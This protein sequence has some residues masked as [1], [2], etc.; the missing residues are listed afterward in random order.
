MSDTNKVNESKKAKN[1]DTTADKR[2]RSQT[3]RIKDAKLSNLKV[4]MHKDDAEE[5]RKFAKKLYEARGLSL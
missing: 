1:Y 4:V 3:Q 5:V 2:M